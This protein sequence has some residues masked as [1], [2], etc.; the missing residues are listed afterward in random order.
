MAALIAIQMFQQTR[1]HSSALP[2]P[3]GAPR[4]SLKHS[5][6]LCQPL[7][8]TTACN[9]GLTVQATLGHLQAGV[10]V[11]STVSGLQD[12]Q[13]VLHGPNQVGQVYGLRYRSAGQACG[14]PDVGR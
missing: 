12:P 4:P 9:Q 1:L 6:L 3:S 13:V 14:H 11:L 8:K 2:E 5:A 7:T 10:H